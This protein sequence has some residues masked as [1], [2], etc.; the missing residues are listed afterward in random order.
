MLA[1][2]KVK[3]NVG[4]LMMMT[5]ASLL[6]LLS[7]HGDIATC[8]INEALVTNIKV[9]STVYKLVTCS[10]TQSFRKRKFTE[11]AIIVGRSRGS[12]IPTL[13]RSEILIK[14]SYRC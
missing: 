11:N 3:E 8:T 14:D 12:C 1:G 4:R 2:L 10:S 13:T 7:E 6:C 9:L 5:I